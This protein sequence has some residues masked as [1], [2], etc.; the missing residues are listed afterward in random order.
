MELH[1]WKRVAYGPST[2][3]STTM[4]RTSWPASPTRLGATPRSPRSAQPTVG[5]RRPHVLPHLQSGRLASSPS[6]FDQ[7]RTPA[8]AVERNLNANIP[9]QSWKQPRGVVVLDIAACRCVPTV[10][11]IE[12]RNRL[13]HVLC[14]ISVPRKWEVASEQNVR[15]VRSFRQASQRPRG[16]DF[17]HI[18]IELTQGACDTAAGQ[19]LTNH[20]LLIHRAES[21][22]Q[23]WYGSR[24]VRHDPADIDRSPIAQTD[25]PVRWRS[26]EHTSEL[27]SLRHL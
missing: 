8:P 19:V 6:M 15:G 1:A 2:S 21:I 13:F 22:S 26:E 4:P 16:Y 17:G 12:T 18:I 9:R 7:G 25:T 23:K 5:A 14:W 10:E 20:R 27:Q 3:S 11:R 24:A